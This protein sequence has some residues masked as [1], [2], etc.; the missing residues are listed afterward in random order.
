MSVLVERE[1]NLA[2]NAAEV[3][4]AT[5]EIVMAVT[6]DARD[7]SANKPDYS[8]QTISATELSR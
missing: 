4:A 3:L 2:T 6:A 8:F 7:V 5:V 1:I